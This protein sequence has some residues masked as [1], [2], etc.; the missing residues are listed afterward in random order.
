MHRSLQ[1]P[2]ADFLRKKKL[3]LNS[4][5]S[6]KDITFFIGVFVDGMVELWPDKMFA[7]ITL[8]DIRQFVEALEDKKLG[9][10]MG[11]ATIRKK[12]VMYMKCLFDA[13]IEAG[14]IEGNPTQGF[15]YR[16]R[17]NYQ[18][19]QRISR[20]H[21]IILKRFFAGQ[22]NFEMKLGQAIRGILL[23]T[24][25]RASELC[26][27]SDEDVDLVASTVKVCE[28]KTDKGAVLVFGQETKLALRLYLEARSQLPKRASG[29]FFVHTRGGRI[30]STQL[31]HMLKRWAG[32]SGIPPISAHMFRVTF[33][34]ESF[35]AD[36]DAFAVQAALRHTTLDMTYRYM[37]TA[38][39]ERN[40]LRQSLGSVE[41]RLSDMTRMNI[42][43]ES[44]VKKTGEIQAATATKIQPSFIQ[45]CAYDG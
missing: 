33:A 22:N 25:I 24:G 36:K 8:N 37:R 44:E 18:P 38:L 40:Q 15:A 34:V 4:P 9:H 28:G 11:R 39:R 43:P 41:D 45:L 27:L 26:A 29:F 17:A 6:L 10:K 16:K 1:K 21:L 12:V 31:D 13:A 19:T 30:V 23:D 5:L 2:V 42:Q 35:L 32:N 7:Q 3:E 14:H 20:E